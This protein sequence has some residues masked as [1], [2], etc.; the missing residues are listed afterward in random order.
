MTTQIEPLALSVTEAAKLL[1]ISRPTLYT[2]LHRDD[3]PVFK[4]G[5]RTLISA[6]GL[7]EWVRVQTGNGVQ[8]NG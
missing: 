3:F 5:G 8:A 4:V 2:L 7:R 1:C 6:E